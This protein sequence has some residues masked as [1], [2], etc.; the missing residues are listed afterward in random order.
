MTDEAAD[1]LSAIIDKRIGEVRTTNFDITFG[2][3]VS[4]HKNKELIIQPEYQRLFRWSQEQRSRLIESIL[5]ECL[6][7]LNSWRQNLKKIC[8]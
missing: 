6:S 3:I 2:E 4:L 8:H 5:L 7:P 1:S